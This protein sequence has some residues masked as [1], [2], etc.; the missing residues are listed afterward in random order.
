M[1]DVE[2]MSFSSS[3]DKNPIL[4]SKAFC[5]VIEEYLDFAYVIFK[6]PLL[7]CKRIPNNNGVQIYEL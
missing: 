3:K 6:V 5:G 7:K 1:I 4:A 2:S